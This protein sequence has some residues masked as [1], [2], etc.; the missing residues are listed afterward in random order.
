MPTPHPLI[1]RVPCCRDT[2]A[3]NTGARTTSAG[4]DESMP[5]RRVLVCRRCN[6]YFAAAP[7]QKDGG[8]LIFSALN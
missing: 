7:H 2:P 1:R 4:K 8:F 5:L 3:D 6:I